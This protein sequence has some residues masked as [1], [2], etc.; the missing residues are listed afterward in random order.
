MNNNVI[1]LLREQAADPKKHNILTL[2][3]NPV[4]GTYNNQDQEILNLTNIGI[5]KVNFDLETLEISMSDFRTRIKNMSIL[6]PKVCE[7]FFKLMC[8]ENSSKKMRIYRRT[9]KKIRELLDINTLIKTMTEFQYIKKIMFSKTALNL[10]SCFSEVKGLNNEKIDEI[11]FIF[12]RLYENLHAM[13]NHDDKDRQ[14]KDMD[15]YMA[16]YFLQNV[17]EHK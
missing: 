7:I 2:K 5:K 10:F 17:M 4:V 14:T 15:V 1:S 8:C 3:D 16:E 11:H 12:K 9:I 13:D 6:S